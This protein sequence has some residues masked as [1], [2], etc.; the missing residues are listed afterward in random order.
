MLPTQ[1][2]E[3]T[4]R[5]LAPD[6]AGALH[7]LVQAN[8]GHLTA[9]GDYRDQVAASP[10]DMAA[11][12]ADRTS[13]KRRFGIFLGG[14]IIGRADLTP[15]EPPRFGLGYWLAQNA[16]GKGYAQAALTSLMGFAASQLGA[17]E[18]YAGVTH[19]NEPSVT[20]LARLGF[21]P[22]ATFERYIRFRR[23]L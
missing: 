2:P 17:T 4:L 23:I 21:V 14:T 12:F 13:G 11:E 7:A 20:L 5:E 15:V 22:V 16:T 8:Q 10:E 19:G 18:V 3:L 9:H 6:D 1:V